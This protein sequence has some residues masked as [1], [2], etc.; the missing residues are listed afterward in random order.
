MARMKVADNRLGAAVCAFI[1]PLCAL[2]IW[3]VV[4]LGVNDEWSYVKTVQ[5]L[6]QTGHIVYNGWATAMLGWQLYLGA[7]FVKL[8]GFSFTAVRLSILPVAVATIYLT[9]RVLIRCGIDE[10]NA[11]L[12]TLTL[13]LSP[14]FVPLSVNF[15]TDVPGLFCIVLCLYACLR[16]LQA[17][18]DNA[19]LGWIC[20]AAFSNAAG[21]TVRQIAWLGVL[22][23]VPSTLWLLRRRPRILIVGLVAYFTSIVFISWAIRWFHYQPYSVPEHLIHG[24]L[25]LKTPLRAA[26]VLLYSIPELGF[27]LLPILLFFVPVVPLRD[28][29]AVLLLAAGGLFW[30]IFAV[31]AISR[32]VNWQVPYYASYI[33]VYGIM[34]NLDLPHGVIPV[35][36]TPSF[37]VLI[38]FLTALAMLSFIA[39]V[40]LGARAGFQIAPQSSPGR[41]ISWRELATLLVPITFCYFVVL[42]PRASSWTVHDRY[43]LTPLV[44]VLIPVLLCYQ[45]LV[46]PRL[47]QAAVLPIAAYAAFAVVGAHDYFAKERASVIAIQELRSAGIS[48]TSIDG[49]WEY[50]GW[51][52]IE[53]AGSTY[54]AEIP[55]LWGDSLMS[56]DKRS[57]G[58]CD[59]ILLERFPVLSP[60]YGLAFDAG[61]CLGPA[62][63]APVPYRTWLPPHQHAIYIVKI[64]RPEPTKENSAS[65]QMKAQH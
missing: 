64:G 2:V 38:T 9:H 11:A 33:S 15:M 48:V 18:T 10:W 13:A 60:H 17:E 42:M 61:D 1:V 6:A 12:G 56:S 21:G 45:E 46:R 50:N 36:L 57:F 49:G 55:V 19:A 41:R 40:A 27:L 34:Q 53:L 4:E 20:F 51:N 5:I 44:L 3:P 47:P 59:P 23:M 22:V 25:T 30:V 65:A 58:V 43:M 14:L 8:F 7:L 28:R 52:Q 39:V 37:R 63:F 16:A 31:F 26:W 35:V 24:V 29:R 54:A 62:G 32:G